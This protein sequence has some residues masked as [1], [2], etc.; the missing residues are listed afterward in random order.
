MLLP[1]LL[2]FV[3]RPFRHVPVLV[4]AATGTLTHTEKQTDLQAAHTHTHEYIRSYTQRASHTLI[5]LMAVT[6]SKQGE[7]KI[8]LK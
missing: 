1:L 2:L 8:A 6:Q 4:P 7:Q 5:H 3:A